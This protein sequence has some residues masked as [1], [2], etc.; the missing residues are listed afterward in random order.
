[1]Y[2]KKYPRHAAGCVW[3]CRLTEGAGIMT[4]LAGRS[5]WRGDMRLALLLGTGPGRHLAVPSGVGGQ[6]A[7]TWSRLMRIHDLPKTLK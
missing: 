3:G 1:M 4:R 5:R 6:V 2:M 7:G